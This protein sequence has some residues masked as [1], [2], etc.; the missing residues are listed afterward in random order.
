[1][2]QMPEDG[3]SP[4]GDLPYAMAGLKRRSSQYDRQRQMAYGIMQQG[5]DTSPIAHPMQGVSRLAQALVGS[6]MAGRAD[7][8][9]AE[10]DKKRQDEFG[11]IASIADPNER[12][13]AYGKLD[14][15]MGM[16]F[17][18]Q[19]AMQ[20]AAAKRNADMFQSGGTQIAAGY[21]MQPPGGGQGGAAGAIAG[22]E[23]GGRYDAVG[24]ETGKG[25]ALGKFQV[26]SFNVAPW[27]KEVL[28]QELTPEQF[29]AS[30]EAQE[31]VFQSKFGSYVQKY[32]PGGAAR[33]WFAGEGGMNNPNAA[34]VNGMTVA[35][36]EKKFLAAGGGQGAMPTPQP[37]GAAPQPPNVAR[38]QPSPELL[39]RAQ[40]LYRNGMFGKDPQAAV[41]GARQWVES[42][43]E[44]EWTRARE[45]ANTVYKQQYDE[46]KSAQDEAKKGPQK[47][48]ENATTL[49]KEYSAEPVVK[50]YRTV[51]PMLE[52]AKDATT[53]PSRAAD[54]NLV[55]A[56]AKLMDPDS[57]VR[58]SE[59]GMVMATGTVGDKI[60]AYLGQLNGGPMLKPE[61][62]ANLIR[63]LESRF[64]PMQQS[65][66]Q[67]TDAYGK[68][69]DSG[70]VPRE[71]VILPIRPPK[72]DGEQGGAPT[73]PGGGGAMPTP[74]AGFRPLGGR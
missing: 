59:T 7:S 13:A 40:D 25:R 34:D 72:A 69:A 24:P 68:I 41:A 4:Y 37:P 52:T 60:G 62:R 11:R 66:Q 48:F 65:Y 28:G 20:E 63:E 32:G 26:M 67:I 42:Q 38:P 5:M 57:V 21:G 53:R 61:T 70:G 36:Y 23:S 58:E 9:E 16:K 35:N 27:T 64:G 2:S 8:M 54:I 33:A 73:V 17:G 1:M 74:P 22:I 31:K 44:S 43:L 15:E 12:L 71:H 46:W 47:N 29:L 19:M 3:S 51:V 49:R 10:A 55:Y 39:A 14:P 30:P 45:G 6:L 56:F 50:Q 18:A